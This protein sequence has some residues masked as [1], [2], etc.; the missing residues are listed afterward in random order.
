[1]KTPSLE[2]VEEKIDR[3]KRHLSDLGGLLEAALDPNRYQ[4]VCE[5]EGE[6]GK[7]AY[8]IEGTPLVDP[9]WSVIVGDFLF[10]LRSALDHL[11][12]QLVILDGG[13]PNENT[14]FPILEAAPVDRAGNRRP[15][16]LKPPVSSREILHALE[17]AQPYSRMDGAAIDAT[18]MPLWAIKRLN[19]IDKHRLLLVVACVLNIRDMSW[20]LPEGTPS[21]RVSVNR[22][23]LKDGD[24]VAW[25]DF[26]GAKT[27]P[28]FDP[29][30]TLHVALRE[31][32]T[33]RYWNDDVL[34]VLD[35]FRWCVEDWVLDHTFRPLF[36]GSPPRP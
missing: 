8:R 17:R 27:P 1:M 13:T 3:A 2:G 31:P 15:V 18:Q 30:I 9:E 23:S 10:N 35:T 29:H 19:N 32:G 25:F 36:T 5:E 33:P 22:R 34:R 21:P 12:W 20:G 24:S 11:A 16:Q 26:Q 4:V 6:T 14:Q 7:Y 28:N